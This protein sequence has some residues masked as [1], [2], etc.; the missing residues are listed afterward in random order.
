MIKTPENV[1][2]KHLNDSK[3]FIEHSNII[4]DIYNKTD[5]YNP[6]RKRKILVVF[7]MTADIMTNKK[8][9]PIIKV[10]IRCRNL[11]ISLVSITK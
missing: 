1:G 4:N 3:A 7:D 5:D 9:R 8:F 10:F 6:T 11:D 2:L